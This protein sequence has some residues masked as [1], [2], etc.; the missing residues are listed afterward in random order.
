[1]NQIDSILWHEFAIFSATSQDDISKQIETN[2]IKRWWQSIFKWCISRNLNNDV[3]NQL[4]VKVLRLIKVSSTFILSTPLKWLC[5]TW[6]VDTSLS[7]F[8]L[9][10]FGSP[11][12]IAGSR[13]EA[14]PVLPLVL[15]LLLSTVC[16]IQP[17]GQ[18]GAAAKL[19]AKVTEIIS[20]IWH[21][22]HWMSKD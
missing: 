8:G 7:I 11:D 20:R 13:S 12:G 22:S 19:T 6:L 2:D 17:R 10:L 18:H 21:I 15:L 5:F 4:S 1:M 14:V 3:N 16:L 9:L